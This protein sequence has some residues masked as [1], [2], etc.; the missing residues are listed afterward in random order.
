M[1]GLRKSLNSLVSGT[2]R[3]L[4]TR[5]VFWYRSRDGR[6]TVT[7]VGGAFITLQFTL[8]TCQVLFALV[9]SKAIYQVCEYSLV[10]LKSGTIRMLEMRGVFWY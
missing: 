2:I 10:R 3:L 4:E 5:G 1:E 8:I 9:Y 7:E 6:V